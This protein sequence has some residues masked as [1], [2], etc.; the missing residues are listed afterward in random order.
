MRDIDAPFVEQILDVS[1]RELEADDLGR[2]LETF[3]RVRHWATRRTRTPRS[4]QSSSGTTLW[5]NVA[6]TGRPHRTALVSGLPVKKCTDH[7]HCFVRIVPNHIVTRVWYNLKLSVL[8][9][10]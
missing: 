1:Q 5:V 7:R 4:S 3:E 6:E 10:A 8:K 9:E 2:R